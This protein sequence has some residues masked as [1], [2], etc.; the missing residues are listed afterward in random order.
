MSFLFSPIS[1]FA[2]SGVALG[3]SFLSPVSW[4]LGL[5][6]IWL[7]F[8]AV[9]KSVT[10]KQLWWGGILSWFIKMLLVFSW[11]WSI[12]PLNWFVVPLAADG[13]WGIA[14][15]WIVGASFLT[16][17]GGLLALLVPII[18]KTGRFWMLVL[19]PVVWL[20]AEVFSA[21]FFSFATLGDGGYLSSSYSYGFVGYILAEHNLLL[22]AASFG[23]VYILTIIAVFIVCAV[24]QLQN[25]KPVLAAAILF[26]VVATALI[27]PLTSTEKLDLPV[28]LLETRF[29][30][31][32][33]ISSSSVRM[34]KDYMVEAID[35]A[36]AGEAKYV[37]LPEDAHYTNLNLTPAG[38][39]SWFL[40]QNKDSDAIVVDSGQATLGTGDSI[41]R[42]TVYDGQEKQ[43]WQFDKQYLVP[44]GEYTP[45]FF[46]LILQLFRQTE[47]LD[48]FKSTAN[49]VPGPIVGQS[50]MPEHLP[51]V[52]FCFS[53]A[54]PK[55]VKRLT[56]DTEVPF[57]AHI[58]SHAWFNDSAVLRHEQTA[59]LKVQS[60]W[61]G[62][63]I[64]QSAN[65]GEARV[66]MP[67]GY[68]YRPKAVGEGERWR[69]L[70]ADL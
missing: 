3:V 4:F 47:L 53:S 32:F 46:L 33:T 15:Y 43:A 13:F 23:G 29:D 20:I 54:D 11:G 2:L 60:V 52:L 61:S 65:M 27:N 12:Y 25:I 6:G 17:G 36:L 48:A 16:M 51:R 22:L 57:V 34:Q 35:A 21:F 39:Y 18:K 49:Y 10:K 44:Q 66:Y 63:P 67:T 45:R 59:M 38:A 26:G 9:D 41:M 64:V 1:L 50:D 28:A 68:S 7:F 37:I 58:T 31:S 24:R 5:F 70:R 62:V 56:E 30:A 42:A 69:V 14:F 19:L 55:A 8:E 40:F